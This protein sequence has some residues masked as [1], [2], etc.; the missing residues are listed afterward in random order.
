M[1]GPAAKPSDEEVF[2]RWVGAV[3]EVS[4]PVLAGFSFTAVIVVTDDAV[5]F[6][7]PGAVILALAIATILLFGAIQGSGQA[8]MYFSSP[9]DEQDAAASQSEQGRKWA[10]RT[11]LSHLWGIVALLAGLGLALAPLHGG[12]AEGSLRWCAS[13]AVLVVCIGQA[14]YASTHLRAPMAG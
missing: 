1:S 7:W 5:N 8:R 11:R 6:R 12:G 9:A 3:G 10:M 14:G 13:I 4:I 2:R